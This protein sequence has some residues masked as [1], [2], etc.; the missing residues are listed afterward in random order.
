LELL[1]SFSPVYPHVIT[2]RREF[3]MIE[4]YTTRLYRSEPHV[5]YD[6]QRYPQGNNQR[7]E[8]FPSGQIL[9]PPTVVDGNQFTSVDSSPV[10]IEIAKAKEYARQ[11]TPQEGLRTFLNAQV[12]TYLL[13][14]IFET[15]HVP[16]EYFQTEGKLHYPGISAPVETSWLKAGTNVSELSEQAIINA[17]LS[18]II[19]QPREV[20]EAHSW[21][22][23]IQPALND[24]NTDVLMFLSPP[25]KQKGFG[26]YTFLNI[27]VKDRSG[28]IHMHCIRVPQDAQYEKSMRLYQTINGVMSEHGY[29]PQGPRHLIS[30]LETNAEVT[31]KHFLMS[32][33]WGKKPPSF[34]I[35]SF[36]QQIGI[37]SQS[38]QEGILNLEKIQNDYTLQTMI[39]GYKTAILSYDGST[40]YEQI[41]RMLD[42]IT[43][44]A[45]ELKNTSLQMI[46]TQHEYHTDVPRHY[47]GDEKAW[48]RE[49][50]Q[51]L[52]AH[53]NGKETIKTAGGSCPSSRKR[54]GISDL[55]N[56]TGGIITENV[57][58]AITDL[59]N[60]EKLTAEQAK[61]QI[62]NCEKGGCNCNEPHFHCPQSSCNHVIPVGQGIS[63][64]PSCGAG[65]TCV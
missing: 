53:Y 10:D 50:A 46:R 33:L 61:N 29:N 22:Q 3:F 57:L 51:I 63:S 18:E 23:Y 25:S 30:A 39:E 27:Y 11:G 24:P 4:T 45:H 37:P 40:P 55:L 17:S 21:I 20:A 12:E 32:P 26:D 59:N 62:G 34:E 9:R 49:Q 19:H 58:H 13:E 31:E 56:N 14:Y 64:C 5:P 65:A 42:N 44:R 1:T 43:I 35:S 8:L 6:A 28:S 16:I 36:L 15:P 41:Q 60:G 54:T 38:I 47:L 2:P 7:K 48:M 52:H